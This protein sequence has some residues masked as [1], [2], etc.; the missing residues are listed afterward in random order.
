MFK[1]PIMEENKD[2]W[3]KVLDM[4]KRKEDTFGEGED[5]DGF[6]ERE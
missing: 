6:A 1:R 2:P 4:G 5:C 3:G